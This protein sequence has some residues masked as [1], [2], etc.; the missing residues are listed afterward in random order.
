MSKRK[1]PKGIREWN[2]RY[3]VVADLG[4][5]HA[6]K[7]RQRTVTVAWTHSPESTHFMTTRSSTLGSAHQPTGESMETDPL[8]S[9][10][11]QLSGPLWMLSSQVGQVRVARP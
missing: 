2:G 1:L 9:Q 10:V 11:G 8:F 6:G 4:K 5:D 3:R 7:R